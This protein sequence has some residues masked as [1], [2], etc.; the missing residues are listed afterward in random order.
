MTDHPD[1]EI[2]KRF[3]AGELSSGEA[4]RTDQHLSYCSEC[5]DRADEISTRQALRLLDSWLSPSYDEALDRAAERVVERLAGLSEDPRSTESLLAELLREPVSG[6]RR[7]IVN[8]ERFHSLKLCQ[9]LQSR[10]RKAWASAPAAALEMADLS[11]EVTQYLDSG[12]YGSCVVEDARALAWSY[13]GNAFRIGSDYRRADQAL[14]QA[15]SHHVMA[16]EDAYTETELLV[17]TASLRR[18]QTRYQE[19]VQLSDRAIA[20]YREGQDSHLEGAALILKGLTLGEDGRT[21]EAIPVLRAGL[22]RIEPQKDP[23]LLSAGSH[24]LICM[25]AQGGAPV[26]AQEL[27]EQNRHLFQDLDQLD[28]ARIQ[29]F[30]SDIANE[31]G[32]LAEAKILLHGAR[33][34]FLDL[35]LGVEV[36]Q[37]SLDL[38]RVYSVGGEPGQAKEILAEVIP[39]GEALGL[40]RDVFLARLLYENASRR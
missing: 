38:A 17:F 27:I 35:Q 40:S 20:L 15:W 34:V 32:N 25:I 1:R 14:D 11:V 36:V 29:W 4:Q 37:T 33:E 24:N 22:D 16:G 2:L 5:R 12:L 31:L 18:D 19:A 26:K 7:R 28:L 39:L 8:D 30:E 9:L 6:R 13:L 23:R 10:S 21:Q 3:V